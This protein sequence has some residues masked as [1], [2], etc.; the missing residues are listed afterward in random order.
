MI[1]TRRAPAAGLA[2]LIVFAAAGPAAGQGY[3]DAVGYTALKDRLGAAAPTGAGVPVSQ[4]EAQ[5]GANQYLPDQSLF[6]NTTILDRSADGPVGGLPSGHA[7]D[8]GRHFYGTAR[9]MAFGVPE[10]HAYMVDGSL[11]ARDWLGG[12]YLRLNSIDPPRAEPFRVQNHSWVLPNDGSPGADPNDPVWVQALRRLDLAVRRDNLVAVV[13]VAGG[14]TPIPTLLGNGY[15]TI[16]VGLTP[17]TPGVVASSTGPSTGDGV[18]R[19]KPDIVSPAD[20]AGTSYSTAVVSA[21][22]ALLVQTAAGKADPGQRDRAGRVETIKAA[23]LSGATKAEFAALGLPWQRT[24]NGSFVEPLD[25]RFGAGE[26]N[27][28]NSHRI[29]DA[30]EQTGTDT[31]NDALAGWDHESFTA[32]GQTRR[33]YLDVPAD[34]GGAKVSATANWLRRVTQQDAVTFTATLSRVELRLFEADAAGNLGALVDGSL[35]PIDNVQHLHADLLPGQR[36]AIE[37]TAAEFP[38]NQTGEDVAIAWFTTFVPVPEPAGVLLLG[39]AAVAAAAR[40]L[41]RGRPRT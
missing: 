6:P 14:G 35:S 36:Y 31:L 10:V 38:V 34:V 8:V 17:T 19:S 25:R 26:L 39:A 18:G 28:D 21:A 1:A 22:S 13:G 33:Y 37:I 2:G 9:G 15:N 5:P 23:L 40:L 29:L 16:A 24:N 12:A 3:F 30:A 20:T 11:S 4:V 32:V 41:R 7:N 27:I